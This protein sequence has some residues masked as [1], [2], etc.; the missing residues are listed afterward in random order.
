MVRNSLGLTLIEVLVS[1][2]TISIL[3]ALS[4]VAAQSIRENARS[5]ACKNNL[6]QIGMAVHLFEAANVRLPPGTIGYENV[7]DW[8]DYR[9]T[10]KGAYWKKKQQT[11][12][13]AI[14]LPF[15]DQEA[16]YRVP[17]GIM[18]NLSKDLEQ[19][20][21]TM[22]A[23]FGQ[24]PGFLAFSQQKISV[25]VCPSDSIT[26]EADVNFLGG[27]Q[28][29]IK[30][31]E[32]RISYLE[33]LNT[34]LPGF[35]SATNYLGCSGAHSG[36]VSG[37]SIDRFRGMMSSGE[38]IG[39]SKILDGTSHTIMFCET[40]GGI[41]NGNRKEVQ[42]WNVGGLGRG[43]SSV[44]WNSSQGVYLGDY[45]NSSAVGFGSRHYGGVNSVFGDGSVQT[46]KKTIERQPL[47]SLCG[48]AD[49]ESQ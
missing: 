22:I 14:I 48:I 18:F 2:A 35:Y 41:R 4:A 10:P 11:S 15:L 39:M 19:F 26:S 40:L 31:G 33:Y 32:D 43:R 23:W 30:D 45:L 8:N 9:N 3:L 12:A 38:N 28:P 13:L 49:G 34:E 27:T 1:I 24:I 6:R 16:T 17:D 25:F 7:L 37:S 21:D 47:F 20:D 29:V 46:F 42:P 5:I 36:G 44:S